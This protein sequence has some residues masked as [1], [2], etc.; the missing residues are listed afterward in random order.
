MYLRMVLE[1]RHPPLPLICFGPLVGPFSP[2]PWCFPS[3]I[4]A[5]RLECDPITWQEATMMVG[6]PNW[7][8]GPLDKGKGDVHRKRRVTTSSAASSTTPAPYSKRQWRNWLPL[9]SWK[10]QVS[11]TMMLLERG[12]ERHKIWAPICSILRR[13]REHLPSS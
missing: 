3:R 5:Y 12:G 8:C 7:K 1:G 10:A 4:H 11:S 6:R 2:P 9:L 13:V